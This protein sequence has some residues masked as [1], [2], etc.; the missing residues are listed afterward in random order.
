MNNLV[1]IGNSGAARE[2]Y[3]ILQL[4]LA[5]SPALKNT[6]SFKGFLSWQHFAGS[7]K[8]T[9]VLG[10]A[11]D[12]TVCEND[13][14]IIGV[15]NPLLRKAIYQHFCKLKAVFF[16]L[17]HPLCEISPSAIFGEANIFQRNSTVF[18]DAQIGNANYFNGAVNVSHD[19]VVG[20]FNFLGPFSMV[21]GDARLGSGNALGVSSILLPKAR[22]GDRNIIAPGSIVFK[23]CKNGCR[24]AGNPALNIGDLE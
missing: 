20:D 16:T 24:L 23:G 1:I 6:H 11:D 17:I 7:P 13:C 5:A 4:M 3:D 15:G 10:D 2:C 19:A 9:P 14:F 21:L 8:A 12:Y 22:V 18:A